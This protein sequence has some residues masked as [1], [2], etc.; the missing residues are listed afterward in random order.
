MTPVRQV[1]PIASRRCQT[2]PMNRTGAPHRR[3]KALPTIAACLLA[4]TGC[5]LGSS[6]SD[7]DALQ[8]SA[9]TEGPSCHPTPDPARRQF[10]IGY[11]SLMQEQSRTQT[12]PRA[13]GS[14]PVDLTGFRRGFFTQGAMPGF[15]TVF[16]GVVPD[17]QSRI[18]AVVFEVPAVEIPALDIRE[19]VYCRVLVPP[20]AL[21]MLDGGDAVAGQTWIY[22]NIRSSLGLASDTVP[23]VQSYVDIFLS[24]CLEME[25]RF[26][27]EGFADRCITTTSDWSEHWVNDRLFPRRPMATFPQA[28]AVDSLLSRR[29]PEQF[30]AIRIE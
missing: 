8:A 7:L 2:H 13:T 3:S 1:L 29:L 11:G 9:P 19:Y 25:Q 10:V 21:S 24:G 12:A 18:N 14:R 30:A 5:G 23:L 22:V 20:G 16:L 26:A 28:K 27:L 17:A 6:T 4:L 15:N